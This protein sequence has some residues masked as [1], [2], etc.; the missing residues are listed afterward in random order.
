M[1]WAAIGATLRKQEL[2]SKEVKMT[3]E[4]KKDFFSPDSN[5]T[6]ATGKLKQWQNREIKYTFVLLFPGIAK[7]NTRTI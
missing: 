3:L 1:F 6:R 7:I 2:Q 4:K 5:L